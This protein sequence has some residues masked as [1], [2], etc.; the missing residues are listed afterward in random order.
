[1]TRRTGL[2][3]VDVRNVRM[4]Q[5]GECPRLAVES[6]EAFRIV[7]KQ[8]GKDFDRDVAVQLRVASA[9]DMAHTPSP[10][11][12]ENLVRTQSSARIQL[13]GRKPALL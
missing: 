6:C 1:M 9:I 12:T 5:R 10:D 11:R 4:I 3:P 2:K 13:H 7:G 8:V